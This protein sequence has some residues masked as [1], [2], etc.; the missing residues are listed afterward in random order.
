L[1]LR[2]SVVAPVL[3][4]AVLAACTEQDAPSSEVGTAETGGSGELSPLEHYLG[5]GAVSFEGGFRLSMDG[6][7]LD[8]PYRPSEDQLRRKRE[9]ERL[10]ADCMRAEGFEYVPY[11]VDPS[12][13]DQPFEDAYALPPA[14][15][16]ARYGYGISTI[17]ADIDRPEDPNEAIREAMSPAE[18]EA[19]WV[20]MH[21][22]GAGGYELSAGESP[23]PLAQSGC[24]GKATGQ[25]YDNLDE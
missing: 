21:G 7:S 16:T 10:I 17:R 3:L 4:I 22:D 6:S 11:V 2:S 9:E 25:V 8:G 5:K 20:A 14:E 24:A 18:L 23:P 19:Y 15:F 1:T 12:D 13:W